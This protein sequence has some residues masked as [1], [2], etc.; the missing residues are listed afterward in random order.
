MHI[1]LSEDARRRLSESHLLSRGVCE[2][3]TLLFALVHILFFRNGFFDINR[4]KYYLLVYSASA[5]AGLCG[6]FLCIERFMRRPDMRYTARRP[7]LAP[8]GA[9]ILSAA[10][11]ISSA[12]SPDPLAALTGSG[13]RY[14]GALCFLAMCA[15]FAMRM[16]A[17]GAAWPVTGALGLSGAL[18]AL[19]GVCNF[20]RF[21]P[22]HFYTESLKPIYHNDFISTIGNI[23]FFSAYMCLLL[24]LFGG[25]FLKT[26]GRRAYL[27]LVPYA[28]CAMGLLA[29]RSESGM[30]GFAAIFIAICLA[31][32][33]TMKEAGRVCVLLGAFCLSALCMGALVQWRG[34]SH[35]ELY[36]GIAT[37]LMRSGTFMLIG[38]LICLGL[39]AFFFTRRECPANERRLIAAQR[40]LLFLAALSAAAVIALMVYFTA[41]NP[42]AQLSGLASYLRMDDHWGT[43]RGFIWK[44]TLVLYN[45][46]PLLQKLFGVGPDS[47]K[48]LLVEKCYDE[49]VT[50]T[51][52][53]FDNAHNEFL[54]LLITGGAVGLLGY[55]LMIAGAMIPLRRAMRSDPALFAVYLALCAH[56]AQSVFNIAQPE[57]T[58]AV[59]LLLAV[60]AG[61]R[62]RRRTPG[63]KETPGALPPDPC[64]GE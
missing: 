28:L 23:N 12:L 4:S 18:C 46:L 54:Q 43:F 49:M 21:D 58:P 9:C 32:M 1:S 57:T 20:L 29:A 51:G 36:A 17:Q 15:L 55:L 53:L 56:L 59:F 33:R 41:I 35:M 63:A 13:G 22:F 25:F 26:R 62:S 3:Y 10:M 40:A 30:I 16:W 2:I 42:S 5:A 45:E 14:A 64:Q 48:P 44:K 34:G 47:L 61:A 37:T 6:L 50:L 60:A 27:F 39:A 8:I 11:L 24:G 31:K 7:M 38:A 19:L 52:I